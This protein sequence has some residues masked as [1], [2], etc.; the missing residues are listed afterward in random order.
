MF[1]RQ[2]LILN[3]VKLTTGVEPTNLPLTTI[4]LILFINL[5]KHNLTSFTVVINN[6]SISPKDNLKHLGQ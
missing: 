5:S 4:K 3:Y 6:H 1:F 2:L